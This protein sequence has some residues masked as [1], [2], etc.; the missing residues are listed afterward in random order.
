MLVSSLLLVVT[1]VDVV[2]VG[3]DGCL[4][5]VANPV[6]DILS[7]FDSVCC[8]PWLFF[9]AVAVFAFSMPTSQKLAT[10]TATARKKNKNKNKM[11]NNGNNMNKNINN[12]NKKQQARAIETATSSP[13]QSYL[14]LIAEGSAGVIAHVYMREGLP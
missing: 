9:L 8:S 2:L 6:A 14:L 1:I 4:A 11:T 10:S 3:G 13:L 5:L 12:K 7:Y